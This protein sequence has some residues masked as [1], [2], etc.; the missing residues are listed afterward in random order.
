MSRKVDRFFY[1]FPIQ[2]VLLNFRKNLALIAVW[3]LLIVIVTGN[4]GQVFGVPYLFLD[5]EYLDAVGFT[6][7]FFVGLTFGGMVIAFHITCYILYGYRYTFVGLL[8]KPF[9]KFSINN[10]LIP[11]IVFLIYL[12]SMIIFQLRN[13]DTAWFELMLMVAGFVGGTV[14]MIA[15]L[16]GYFA[17]TNK[18]I[19][20]FLAGSVDKRLKQVRINRMNA[21]HKLEETKDPRYRVDSFL[22]TKLRSI[23]T[24]GLDTFLDKAA[25]LKVFDQNHF[26]SVIIEAL[27]LL[28]I[29]VLGFFMDSPWFKIPAAASA[30]LIFTVV[31]MLNGAISYWFRSWALVM[32]IILLFLLNLLVKNGILENRTEA[33]GL[34]YS[35]SPAEYTID[36]IERANTIGR[37]Y[38]DKKH[39]VEI[40]DNWH[41]KQH[42]DRPKAVFLCV[43]GGGQ[44]AALWSMTAMSSIDSILGGSLMNNTVLFTGASGGM[45]GAAYYRELYR[46]VL[47]KEID[48]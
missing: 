38:N 15:L 23:S 8:E 33:F 41:G 22:D 27:I 4:F 2:L 6:S 13:E 35:G 10:S 29:V 17:F 34:K 42:S 7:F 5:P 1:S 45:I 40:L 48:D 36:E 20:K 32:T 43:S 16:L 14:T 25:V 9:I 47:N 3:I 12:V 24:K 39:T 44:R 31:I 21:L 26:N 30:M 19:F 28:L 37:I 46:R 11:F 18:D